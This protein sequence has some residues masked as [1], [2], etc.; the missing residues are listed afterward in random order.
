MICVQVVV[1]LQ[2]GADANINA[3]AATRLTA[4][5]RV[6][7]VDG[8]GTSANIRNSNVTNTNVP[9]SGAVWRGFTADNGATLTISDSTISDIAGSIAIFD[10]LRQAEITNFRIWCEI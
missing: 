6:F 3:L 7:L 9:A 10:A 1:S 2:D 8:A 5:E 4:V